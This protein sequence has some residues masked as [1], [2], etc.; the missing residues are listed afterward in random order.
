MLFQPPELDLVDARVLDEVSEM[1]EEL[2]SVLR[3]PRR[4]A[5]TLR[6]NALARAI[7]GSN[8]I[9]G[10]NVEIDDADAALDGDAPLDASERTFAEVEGYRQAL[11]YV[12]AMA[13]DPHFVADAA[14]LRS[15]HFMMLSHDLSK[16]PGQYRRSEIYVQDEES[17]DQVYVGPDPDNVPQLMTELGAAL[18]ASAGM[19]P[20]VAAAMAHLNLVMIHPFR[21]GNGRMARAVQTLMLARSG[22]GQPEFASL[23]EWLGANTDDYYAVL[24]ATGRGVWA[25]ENDAGLWLSFMLR[26]HHLQA[27]TTKQR[28]ERAAETYR[29]L[30]E[31]VAETRV[32]E[33]SVDSLFMAGLGYRIRRTPYARQLGLDARTAT[34]DLAA[35]AEQGLLV[36]RGETRGRHYVAGPRLEAVRDAVGRGPRVVDPNPDVVARLAP[37][38][39]VR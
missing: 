28:F 1:R 20:E 9:E 18:T 22:I 34:R 4:W 25:P 8:S 39:R 27:Q 19:P 6:R 12:L 30:D 15:M 38:R 29:L 3:V 7:R 11:G 31:V 24:A 2:A 17:G 32:P 35:L 33:R 23:E 36:A 37:Y 10:I 14:S 21:D 26:A 5:G 13:A 16:S